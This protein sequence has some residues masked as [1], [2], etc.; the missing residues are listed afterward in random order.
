MHAHG[1]VYLCVGNSL[2]QRSR[3]QFEVGDVSKLFYQVHWMTHTTLLQTKLYTK[4]VMLHVEL[5]AHQIEIEFSVCANGKCSHSSIDS[6][7]YDSVNSMP[8]FVS[9][10]RYIKL[11]NLWTFPQRI[12]PCFSVNMINLLLMKT[13]ISDTASKVIHSLP[14]HYMFQKNLSWGREPQLACTKAFKIKNKQNS[15]QEVEEAEPNQN[16]IAYQEEELPSLLPPTQSHPHS[17]F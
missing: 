9:T 6:T 8:W 7:A 11:H 5:T 13:A 1:H 15:V 16:V 4:Q 12:L 17:V 3:W 2:L 10:H 14:L